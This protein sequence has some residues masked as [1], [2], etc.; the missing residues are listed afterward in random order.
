MNKK[1][2]ILPCKGSGLKQSKCVSIGCRKK[3]GLNSI[4]KFPSKSTLL[5]KEYMKIS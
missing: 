2:Y 3:L 1:K 4:L 5:F